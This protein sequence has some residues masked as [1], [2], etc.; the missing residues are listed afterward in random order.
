MLKLYL[1]LGIPTLVVCAVA[2]A[3]LAGTYALTKDRIAAQKVIEQNKALSAASPDAKSF[4]QVKDKATIDAVSKTAGETPIT[5]VFKALDS[6]G[7]PAGWGLITTPRGY[8]GPMEVV[9]GLDRNGKVTGV[10]IGFNKETPGL[11]TKAI[12]SAGAPPT[13]YLLSFNGVESAEKAG[14]IDGITGATKSSRG[15]KRGVEAALLA[16][17]AVLKGLE[18]GGSK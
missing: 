9:V 6:S 13:P 5:G 15:V 1:R 2:A 7:Q 11:G 4:E 8:G 16:Y 18:G 12:G 10:K 3:G 17:D 14:K